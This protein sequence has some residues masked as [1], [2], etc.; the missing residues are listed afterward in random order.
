VDTV[1]GAA[2]VASL[3]V[4]GTVLGSAP[5]SALPP[6]NV[7]ILPTAAAATP[8]CESAPALPVSPLPTVVSGTVTLGPVSVGVKVGG[9][10]TATVC[11]GS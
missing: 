5:V 9:S 10:S 2:P 6:V 8:T 7:A 4:V 1:L 3:P 11:A